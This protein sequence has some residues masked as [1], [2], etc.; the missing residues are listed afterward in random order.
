M[1]NAQIDTRLWQAMLQGSHEIVK[2]KT[3]KTSK[4][5]VRLPHVFA[6]K[7]VAEASTKVG[8]ILTITKRSKTS[9]IFDSLLQRIHRMIRMTR[10][11]RIIRMTKLIWGWI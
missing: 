8:L 4:L 10:M 9:L 5:A 11:I 1:P 7:K 3:P 2:L 6:G